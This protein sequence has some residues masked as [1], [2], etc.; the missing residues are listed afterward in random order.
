MTNNTIRARSM[1]RLGALVAI[2][3]AA[4]SSGV[5]NGSA[6]STPDGES[7]KF[8]YAV[9]VSG[10]GA[11]FYD[12][13]FQSAQLAV[14]EINEAGFLDRPIELVVADDAG[15]PR[16]SG[17]ICTRLVFDDNVDAIVGAQNSA[18]REGC[19]PV[20][21]QESVPYLYATPYEGGEC[22][23]NFFVI[24]EVPQQQVDPLVR[25]MVE[26]QGSAQW[27]LTGSDYIAMRGGNE[28]GRGVIEDLGAE[29]VGEEY[30]PLGTTDFTPLIAQITGSGADTAFINFLGTDF[31]A[32]LE[33]YSET[34]GTE[35]VKLVTF[36]IP[37]GVSNDA[38]TDLYTAFSYFPTI[39]SPENDSYKA[40]LE[41]AY[42]DEAT[43]P[44]VIS[45]PSY[46]SVWLLARAIEAA[47]SA[48]HEAVIE[49]LHEI[50]FTGPGGEIKFN[51]QGHPTL[52]MHIAVWQDEPLEGTEEILSTSPPA[53]PGDQD[54]GDC[55]A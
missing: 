33:Q 44:S 34:P 8:G 27:F 52:P 30:A 6:R 21:T 28:F 19:L 14:D 17:E 41:E 38:V 47:G 42:G 39:S 29:V 13:L 46:V 20:A 4:S 37:I 24:G 11:V 23:P 10:P 45:V 35:A 3:L 31:I 5:V 15:D 9:S 16:T 53:D 26:E 22:A 55:S 12:H 18:N 32:F 49:A 51:E 40:A 25:Y 54:D 1:R 7:Y 50:S 48:D 2:G 36:G 43:L